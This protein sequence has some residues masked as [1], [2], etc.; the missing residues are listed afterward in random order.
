MSRGL[1]GHSMGGYGTWRLGMK[2]PEIYS[3]LYAMSSCCLIPNMNPNP[4]QFAKL[5]IAKTPQEAKTDRGAT[6]QMASAAAWSPNPNNPPFFFDLPVKD[7]KVRPEIVAKWAANAPLATIDQYIPN[8]KKYKAIA[9][10]VGLQDG[11]LKTNEQLDAL[12]TQEGVSHT[13]ETY[14]GDH[15]S[16]VPVRFDTKVIPFFSNQLSF[17]GEK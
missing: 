5:E 12:L 10:D 17:K 3:S 4:E 8:L 1:A 16:K 11:L 2:H 14:E 15:N 7:G 6:V 9:M 13:F